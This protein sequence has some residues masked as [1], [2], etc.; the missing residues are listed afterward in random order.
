MINTTTG[1][2]AVKQPTSHHKY[3]HR[4]V[5]IVLIT[6]TMVTTSHQLV[7]TVVHN[8]IPITLHKKCVYHRTLQ[9]R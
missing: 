9:L 1:G 5:D 7:I 6:I 2:L 4:H 3:H 8:G